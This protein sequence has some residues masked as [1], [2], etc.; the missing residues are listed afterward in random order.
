MSNPTVPIYT[1]N[2]DANGL[3]VTS[4]KYASDGGDSLANNASFE[5]ASRFA[6]EHMQGKGG[7][8]I[9]HP[10]PHGWPYASDLLGAQTGV[11]IRNPANQPWEANPQTTSRDQLLPAMLAMGL[12]KEYKNLARTQWQI[13]KRGFFAQNIY[14][15]GSDGIAKGKKLPDT[16]LGHLHLM[17]RCWGKLGYIFYP[18]LL[19]FDITLLVSAIVDV[20]P[21]QDP[22]N[23]DDRNGINC[24]IAALYCM[25][26][27]ISYLA[28]KIYAMYRPAT[29]ASL[30][31]SWTYTSGRDVEPNHVMGA[32]VLYFWENNPIIAEA[33]RPIIERY[34]T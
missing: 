17:L 30:N 4:P 1:A 32:L 25:P 20:L 15:N 2:V 9:Y 22:A 3:F 16:F 6:L 33:Y 5:L 11:W 21:H 13:I 24:H 12:N 31:G 23:C 18:L 19:V 27:P 10:G 29:N 8:A 7:Y 26:T 14:T 34:F 28:R